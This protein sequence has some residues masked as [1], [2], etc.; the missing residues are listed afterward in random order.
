MKSHSHPAVASPASPEISRLIAEY[1]TVLTSERAASEHTLRAYQRE[2][3]SFAQ[4]LGKRCGSNI[5]PAQI[6]HPIIRE[7]LGTLYAKNLSKPSV[8]RALAAIRSDISGPLTNVN[9]RC[10]DYITAICGITA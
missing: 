7:Y 1:M 3:T 4:F 5:A 2:L 6:E 10:E 8:A 9:D